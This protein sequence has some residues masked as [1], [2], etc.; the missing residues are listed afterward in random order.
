MKSFL[1][2]RNMKQMSK[3]TACFALVL[4]V[5][6]AGCEKKSGAAAASG[7]NDIKDIK[8]IKVGVSVGNAQEERWLRELD[9]FRAYADQYGFELFLQSAENNTQTQVSQCENMLSQG[10]DVL[11]LMPI[12][13]N[14]VASIIDNAHAEGIKVIAYD[15]LIMN[16]DLDYYVTHDSF[17][18]GV[19]IAEFIV[20]K[21]NKGN[22]IWLKGS[23]ENNNA[24]LIAAG[25]KTILQPLVDRGD[26]KIVLEQWCRGWDPN[27]ALKHT[28]N[29]LTANN[30]N[31]Q[32]VVAPNDNT[33]GGAIQALTAQN[34]AGKIPIAGQDTDLAACQRIVEGT[35]TG[36]VYK[37]IS[38]LNQAAMELAVAIATGKDPQT[39]IM[40]SLGEWTTF[41]N[42]QKEVA[43]F[44]I[45]IIAIDKDNLY[46]IIIE[47]EGFH[48]L[49]D[50]YRNVPRSEW[51]K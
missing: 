7:A 32:A 14:A 26:I 22:F 1:R 8:N 17:K 24:H 39:A 43:T 36:T 34:M 46:P 23:E 48:K 35:Q 51:P 3:L 33:A 30:N 5:G 13:G 15:R 50:V 4:L 18:V 47:Q 45:E 40:S 11:L 21:V 9:M 38:K 6:L 42:N 20:N 16:C 10:V 12:D 31:I 2:G 25:Q 44:A 19:K 37:S 27:E 49:E 41:N 28:E 29:A